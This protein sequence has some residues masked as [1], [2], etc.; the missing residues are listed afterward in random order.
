MGTYVVTIHSSS[1]TTNYFD[2]RKTATSSSSSSSSSSY[3]VRNPF[4]KDHTIVSGF[5]SRSIRKTIFSYQS[6]K[7]P[8]SRKKKEKNKKKIENKDVRE[9]IIKENVNS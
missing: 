1:I 7:S 5:G 9:T 2:S 4:S 6:K 8:S 3:T